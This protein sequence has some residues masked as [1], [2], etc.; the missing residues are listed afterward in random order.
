[1]FSVLLLILVTLFAGTI[2]GLFLM[3]PFAR[4]AKDKR[5]QLFIATLLIFLF[6]FGSVAL[7]I[8]FGS[9]ML[10]PVLDLWNANTP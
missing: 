10:M 9:P 5:Q 7:Y 4:H 8:S 1:M 3:Q 2:L 6:S